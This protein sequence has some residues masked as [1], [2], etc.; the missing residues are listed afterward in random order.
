MTPYERLCSS[1]MSALGQPSSLTC[2]E[3]MELVKYFDSL[4]DR[5]VTLDSVLRRAAA[6]RVRR[7]TEDDRRA[8][9]P[10]RRPRRLP[11]SRDAAPASMTR[12]LD[13]GGTVWPARG[14][15][16]SSELD[17]LILDRLNVVATIVLR[18]MGSGESALSEAALIEV[19]T[20]STADQADRA[21]ALRA[22]GYSAMS[23][24]RVLTATGSDADVHTLVAQLRAADRRVHATEIGSVW[25]LLVDGDV[26]E[27]MGVPVGARLAVGPEVPGI[28]APRSWQQACVAIQFALPS[29]HASGPYPPEEA[30]GG[31][32]SRIGCIELLAHHI[33]ADAIAQAEEVI[34]LN[35]LAQ[36]FSG[37][38]MIRTLQAVAA[39]TEPTIADAAWAGARKRDRI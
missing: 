34:A 35:Q 15:R 30:V 1:A 12:R 4:L 19:A 38:D 26:P 36:E 24:L 2:D 7:R 18:S 14:I 32:S 37:S 6:R 23:H 33:P 31:D 9:G 10:V 3:R 16:D 20:S 22:L 27:A 28:S 11:L 8:R 21:R 39:T 25:A 13:A 17:E 5:G 29:T